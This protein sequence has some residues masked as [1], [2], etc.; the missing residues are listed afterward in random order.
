M[1][2]RAITVYECDDGCRF[3]TEEAAIEYEK[4]EVFISE[5]SQAMLNDINCAVDYKSDAIDLAAWFVDKYNFERKAQ[6]V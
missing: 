3:N 1:G 4:R 6:N 5:L 2:Y